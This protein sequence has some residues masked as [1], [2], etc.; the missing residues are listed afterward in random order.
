MHAARRVRDRLVF[1]AEEE[2]GAARVA[3]PPRAPSQL[4]V[5]TPRLLQTTPHPIQTP[6]PTSAHQREGKPRG[7]S[8]MSRRPPLTTMQ[9]AEGTALPKT[10]MGTGLPPVSGHALSEQHCVAAKGLG[11][12]EYTYMPLCANHM[13]ATHLHNFLFL[14]VC[15]CFVVCLQPLHR[16][17]H[18][19]GYPSQ[20]Q[21]IHI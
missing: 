21:T 12:E 16:Y 11:R 9:P 8:L 13:Q 18:L 14:L 7:K 17:I 15:H 1:Q 4:V 2:A 6:H 19:E 3:L 10:S 20:R 5:N